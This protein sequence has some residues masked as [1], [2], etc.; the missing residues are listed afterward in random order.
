VVGS[1][2]LGQIGNEWDFLD[3]G[4]FDHNNT[5]DLLWQRDDGTLLVHNINNNQVTN[6]Q[7]VETLAA[8]TQRAGIDDYTGDGTDDLVVRHHDGRF[9]LHQIQAS[10]VTQTVNLGLVTNDWHVI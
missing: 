10:A 2:L 9:E 7:V 4:D 6:A 1:A 8:D 5:G 3:G